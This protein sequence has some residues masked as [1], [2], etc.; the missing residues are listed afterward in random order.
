MKNILHLLDCLAMG[1][2]RVLTLGILLAFITL[3]WV[4][5]SWKSR[6]HAELAANSRVRGIAEESCRPPSCDS[7]EMER[8]LFR[9]GLSD[10]AA[11]T[12][13]CEKKA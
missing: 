12:Q 8:V 4:E 5:H 11:L 3:Y 13:F 1:Q 7:K 6:F 2:L 10:I 9:S